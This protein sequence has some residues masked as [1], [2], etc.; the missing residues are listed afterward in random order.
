MCVWC[1]GV[2]VRGVCGMYVC[3]MCSVLVGG[4]YVCGMCIWYECDVC[5]WCA[6]VYV[7]L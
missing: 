6:C 5:V 1:V 4:G 3:V 7:W 2:C